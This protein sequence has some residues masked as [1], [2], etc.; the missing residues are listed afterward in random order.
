[1]FKHAREFLRHIRNRKWES[2]P[3]GGILIAPAGVKFG[4]YYEHDVNGEDL[5]RDH[6]LLTIEGLTYLLNTGFNNGT[7]LTTWYL[8]IYGG[9]YTPTTALTAASFPAT[10]SEITSGSEG[11]SEASRPAWA[12]AAPSAASATNVATKAA[13]TIVTASSLTIY[14]AALCSEAT[15]GAVTGVCASATRFDTP[16]VVYNT[17]VFNLGYVTALTS[18]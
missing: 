13:F 16:R 17:D 15:K 6:N 18:A 10:A 12:L 1:M 11:Y 2:T 7:K 8:P 3:D 4:N 14:G 9:N 5:Q